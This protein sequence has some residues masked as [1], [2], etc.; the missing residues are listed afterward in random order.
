MPADLLFVPTLPS[1]GGGGG[2]KPTKKFLPQFSMSVFCLFL[3][4]KS[5]RGTFV[6][7]DPYGVFPQF[8]NRAV[9]YLTD[10]PLLSANLTNAC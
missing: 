2:R 6:E 9:T 3:P 10:Y 1:S 4:L 8:Y 7:V 5:E